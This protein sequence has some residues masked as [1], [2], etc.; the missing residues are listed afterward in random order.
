VI[1][2]VILANPVGALN[3]LAGWRAHLGLG[4]SV[5]GS[6]LALGH[7]LASGEAVRRLRGGRCWRPWGR[8]TICR[9]G[10]SGP[11]L[12]HLRANF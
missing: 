12:G 1:V 3:F 6:S 4:C 11:C 5:S 10:G 2:I 8:Q 9:G 7:P